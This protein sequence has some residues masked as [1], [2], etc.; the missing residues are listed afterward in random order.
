MVE[1]II[2]YSVGDTYTQSTL[3]GKFSPITTTGLVLLNTTTFSAQASVSIDSVFSSTY[4]NYMVQIAITTITGS[5]IVQLR[6]RDSGGDVSGANYG[7]RSTNFSSLGVA[8]DTH[9]QGRTQTI[10][11]VSPTTLGAQFGSTLNIFLPNLAEKTLATAHGSVEVGNLYT[12]AFAYNT[13]AQF[14]GFSIIASA[15]T[16]TGTIKVY[17]YK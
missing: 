3:D 12:G 14:T 2:A 15:G 11:H 7:Y 1:S 17:G 9:A 13:T 10:A 5:P 16:I 6:F 8:N 4:N